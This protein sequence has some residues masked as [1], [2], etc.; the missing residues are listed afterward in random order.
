MKNVKILLVL[1]TLLISSQTSYAQFLEKLGKRAEEAAK[2]AVIR[3]TEQ[4]VNRETEKTM[5]IVIT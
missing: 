2:E 3:K 1:I 5:V 4:K